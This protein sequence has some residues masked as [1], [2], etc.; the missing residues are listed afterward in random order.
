MGRTGVDSSGGHLPVACAA[1]ASGYDLA[2][3]LEGPVIGT[4]TEGD[5]PTL[6][7]HGVQE[8]IAETIDHAAWEFRLIIL[9]QK[10]EFVTP[11]SG[12]HIQASV[13]GVSRCRRSSSTR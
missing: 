1:V 2:D 3:Q 11:E 6:R 13:K 4:P 7:L 8:F 10:N 12:G 9:C 5:R